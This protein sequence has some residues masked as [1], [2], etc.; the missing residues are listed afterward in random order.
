[1]ESGINMKKI[2]VSV[3]LAAAGAAVLPSAMA[4]SVEAAAPTKWW[5]VSSRLR[6]FYDDNYQV[7][8]NKQGSFGFEVSPRLT[9]NWDLQQTDIGIRYTYGMYY[10]VKRAD[11]GQNPVDHT[12]Q[13]DLWLD[14][15]FTSRVKMN[16]TDSFVVAQDPKLVQGGAVN[17]VGGNNV[18]NHGNAT[19]TTDWTRQFSTATYYG[20]DLYIYSEATSGGGASDAALLNRIEQKVGTDFQWHFQPETMAFVGYSYRWARYTGDKPIAFYVPTSTVLMSDSRDY[21]AHYMYLGASHQFTPSLSAQGQAGA[22]YVD[23]YNNPIQTSTSWA[24]YADINATYTYIP[25]SYAQLGFHQNINSTD[26]ATPNNQGQLTQYQESS[27]VYAT[28]NHRITPKLRGSLIGQYSFSKYQGGAY[29]GQGDDEVSAGVNLN[30]QINN[31]FAAEAGYNFDEL[32][33]N[34]NGRG[35]SRN[36]VYIGLAASY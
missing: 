16:L 33:S 31:H 6:G 20:N 25:G 30:Y 10:Y 35:Y 36:R 13:A 21:N 11:D 29:D 12:H 1:M 24:P 15:A 22:A 19:V 27:V 5:N 32:F 8:N 14:H 3:G 26:V 34:V 9:A 2:F 23:S 18:S 7:S 28:V 4:Q 17:R